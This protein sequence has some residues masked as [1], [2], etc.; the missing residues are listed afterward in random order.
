MEVLQKGPGRTN[1][2]GGRQSG[3]LM[4]LMQL[5]QGTKGYRKEEVRGRAKGR[6]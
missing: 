2:M 4:R 5:L 6:L 1:P 3:D